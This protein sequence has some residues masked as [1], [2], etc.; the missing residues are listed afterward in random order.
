MNE[1]IFV[2]SGLQDNLMQIGLQKDSGAVRK[3]P[4]LS[5]GLFRLQPLG[6][7][8]FDIYSRNADSLSL[9]VVDG[10]D[11]MG[12]VMSL[13]RTGMGNVARLA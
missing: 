6:L 13:M 1:P 10:M 3:I 7:G 9:A 8:G 4:L 2:R 11:Q 12:F 5:Y